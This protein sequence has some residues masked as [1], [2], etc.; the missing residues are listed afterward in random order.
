MTIKAPSPSEAGA[1]M[2]SSSS[3]GRDHH[4]VIIFLH[5]VGGTGAEWTK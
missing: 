1:A 5:G 2:A 4:R 3:S